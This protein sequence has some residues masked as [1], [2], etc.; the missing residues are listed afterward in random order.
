M[1]YQDGPRLPGHAP[2]GARSA[3]KSRISRPQV[4]APLFS[5]ALSAGLGGLFG[6][7]S[8]PN[9]TAPGGIGFAPRPV[10]HGGGLVG[11]P[12]PLRRVPDAAFLSAPRMHAGGIAGLRPDEV[13]AILQRAAAAQ[14]RAGGG[15]IRIVLGD[16]LR[17][18]ILDEA[19]R[20]SVRIVDGATRGPGFASRVA[21]AN[22]GAERSRLR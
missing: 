19:A 13:P 3:R 1:E 2:A 16:G 8:T 15:A 12:A 17:A 9:P 18:K 4:T 20:Q 7:G 21:A 6:G 22:R 5:G 11:A 14:D 10:L